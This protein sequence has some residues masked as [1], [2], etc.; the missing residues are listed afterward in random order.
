MKPT[1]L[2]ELKIPAKSDY[3]GV[4]RLFISGVANRVGFS[5]DEIEDIK[6]AV[7]EACTNAVK[8]AYQ[9]EQGSIILGCVPYQEKMEI[10][11]I[12][13]GQSFDIEAIQ[14]ELGP[15]DQGTPIEELGEGGLGL[16][17]IETL[18]DHV[19]IRN[20]NGITLVMT[21][22]KHKDE[23]KHGSQIQTAKPESQ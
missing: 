9:H 16:F 20:E 5:Y 11:V 17:L 2:I 22:Y 6:V 13:H 12:D 19:Q 1:D 15:L 4:A 18:M 7:A 3:I 21:K 14:A 8:H 10:Y 23:V